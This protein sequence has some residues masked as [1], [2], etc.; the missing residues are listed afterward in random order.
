MSV[1]SFPSVFN[2]FF[3]LS[4]Q[5]NWFCSSNS[6]FGAI[7]LAGLARSPKCSC[8]PFSCRV[9]WNHFEQRRISFV[10]VD[11]KLSTPESLKCFFAK[12]CFHS[13]TS[14]TSVVWCILHIFYKTVLFRTIF[15]LFYEG[16]MHIGAAN[17]FHSFEE[18][19]GVTSW[20]TLRK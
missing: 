5:H 9:S 14:L 1:F 7:L 15:I 20:F 19:T 3:L 4:R 12:A 10:A 13:L 16:T 11:W 6:I 2:L 18:I 8:E 17:H